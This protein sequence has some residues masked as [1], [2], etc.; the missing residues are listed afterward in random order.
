MNCDLVDTCHQDAPSSCI[1]HQHQNA[2]NL[3]KFWVFSQAP[4][5]NIVFYQL[6]QIT[7]HVSGN[8]GVV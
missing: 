3:K 7:T 8:Q 1:H 2:T 5:A 4:D 6:C